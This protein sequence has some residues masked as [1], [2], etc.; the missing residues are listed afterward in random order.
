[1]S[2]DK[3]LDVVGAAVG[4]KK[5]QHAG[6]TNLSKMKNRPMILIGG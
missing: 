6:M 3:L 1:V 5:A 4:R 2:E